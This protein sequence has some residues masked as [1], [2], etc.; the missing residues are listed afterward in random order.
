MRFPFRMPFFSMEFLFQ[1]KYRQ[2]R[3]DGSWLLSHIE[4]GGDQ[5]LPLSKPTV[6]R[7]DEGKSTTKAKRQNLGKP[8]GLKV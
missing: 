2:Q 6:G 3:D 1:P 7:K 8:R 4:Q 5:P